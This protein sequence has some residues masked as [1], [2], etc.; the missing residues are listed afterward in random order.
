MKI[1]PVM[2]VSPYKRQNFMGKAPGIDELITG[3]SQALR[4]NS[5]EQMKGLL[6]GLHDPFNILAEYYHPEDILRIK[7]LS[8]IAPD[9]T[10]ASSHPRHAIFVAA[11]PL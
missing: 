10:V 7:R 6:K 1:M 4:D 11:R 9:A 3:V 5:P 2:A 8:G